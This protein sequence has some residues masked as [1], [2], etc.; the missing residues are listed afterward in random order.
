[1]AAQGAAVDALTE[2]S[3]WELA[4][5]KQ[6][7]AAEKIQE[8]LDL[9]AGDNEGESEEGDW[10]DYEEDWDMEDYEEGEEG[11]P[12]SMDM[13]GD[14]AAGGEMQPLPLP[15]Y[16]VEDVLMEEQGNMQFR[17]QERAKANA[18][19]VEKDW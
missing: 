5:A 14:L 16:S 3:T 19:K 4:R 12:S 9:L 6:Q 13:T 15:N 8:I 2:W 18:G 10:E 11:T 7:E 17:Q 1:M